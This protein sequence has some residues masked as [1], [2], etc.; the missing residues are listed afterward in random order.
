MSKSYSEE[1]VAE[2]LQKNTGKIE[3]ETQMRTIKFL[4]AIPYIILI[5]IL[6][7][8]CLH[9]HNKSQQY[10]DIMRMSRGATNMVGNVGALRAYYP[11]TNADGSL[12]AP[13]SITNK[14]AVTKEA[15]KELA[16]KLEAMQKA[17]DLQK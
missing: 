12:V 5:V 15:L 14:F 9:F 8:S 7:L 1:E 2:L 17:I 11:V 10:L 3:R 16:D 4:H 13:G 6:G